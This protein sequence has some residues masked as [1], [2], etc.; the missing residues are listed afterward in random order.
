MPILL[1]ILLNFQGSAHLFG[2]GSFSK[3]LYPCYGKTAAQVLEEELGVKKWN[4]EFEKT[5]DAFIDT[6]MEVLQAQRR[7]RGR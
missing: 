7:R 4:S 5:A 3:E 1:P 2:V 6:K